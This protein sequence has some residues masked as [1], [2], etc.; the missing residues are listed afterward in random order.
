[1]IIDFPDPSDTRKVLETG[2]NFTS[3]SGEP[4]KIASGSGVHFNKDVTFVFSYLDRYAQSVTNSSEI[5]SNPFIGQQ[6]IDILRYGSTDAAG[7]PNIAL[8]KFYTGVPLRSITIS[9][10]QNKDIFGSY[11]G[12]FAIQSRINDPSTNAETHRSVYKTFA[13]VPLINS[14]TVQDGSGVFTYDTTITPA[15]K[16]VFSGDN[17]STAGIDERT[18][19]RDFDTTSAPRTGSILVNINYANSPLYTRFSGVHVYGAT[20][21]TN[22]DPVAFPATSPENLIRIVP[23]LNQ[24][25]NQQIELTADLLD[26][27]DGALNNKYYNFT[28]VP[29]SKIGAGLEFGIGPHSFAAE[30]D[31][32]NEVATDRVRISPIPST[33]LSTP[34]PDEA[35]IYYIT[36]RETT[37]STVKIDT[38]VKAIHHNIHYMCKVQDNSCNIY[39]TNL[40]VTLTHCSDTDY[41][42]Q[43]YGQSLDNYGTRPEFCISNDSSNVYLEVKMDANTPYDYSI[44]RTSI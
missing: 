13:N 29:Y 39:T 5:N 8:E 42:V 19:N 24:S 11:S 7:N 1:M 40:M 2:A 20:G 32:L 25:K 27:G 16:D 12:N 37:T 43:E 6:Q 17:L 26:M 35:S 22:G 9:E 41:E 38:I 44:L 10:Q 23:A 3:F 21:I 30:P 18:G 33:D 14:V 36:G 31:P 34:S 28:L 15:S 4:E